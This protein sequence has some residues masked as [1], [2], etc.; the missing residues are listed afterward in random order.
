MLLYYIMIYHTGLQQC[1]GVSSDRE[2]R[3]DL[4]TGHPAH[5]F[6]GCWKNDIPPSP[7]SRSCPAARLISTIMSSRLTAIMFLL[8]W[9]D[10]PGAGRNA[11]Q[12][13][14]QGFT[15]IGGRY[16]Q[17]CRRQRE[18]RTYLQGSKAKAIRHSPSAAVNRASFMIAWR[19]LFSV[20]APV[21]GRDGPTSGQ[22]YGHHDV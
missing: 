2:H 12:L 6:S 5:R 10:R 13:C 15:G 7:D 1:K 8:L 14:R 11:H 21:S 16:R 20:S 17:T 9:Q 3:R 19:D 4:H 18:A 22:A